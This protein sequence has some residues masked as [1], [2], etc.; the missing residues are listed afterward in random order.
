MDRR[1]ADLGSDANEAGMH[2]QLGLVYRPR[3]L[4]RCNTCVVLT[5]ALGVGEFAHNMNAYG[6]VGDE[7]GGTTQL[8]Q[9]QLVERV[10]IRWRC[11]QLPQVRCAIL[12]ACFAFQ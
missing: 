1:R 3:R 2:R 4:C 10:H 7:L 9:L 5:A 8:V 11:G 6:A 12:I